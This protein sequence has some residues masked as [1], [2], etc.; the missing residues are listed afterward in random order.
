MSTVAVDW[1]NTCVKDF[2]PGEGEWLEG[3]Q[4]ALREFAKF[5]T[6]LIDSCRANF[7]EGAALIRRVLDKAGL[8]HIKIHQYPGKPFADEYVGDNYNRYTRWSETSL[9]VLRRLHAHNARAAEKKAAVSEIRASL[10]PS[11]YVQPEQPNRPK[12][13]QA[14]FGASVSARPS[15]FKTL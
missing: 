9:E 3:A 14:G 13:S 6:V 2:F 1:D 11:R 5:S 8:E 4:D 12:T 10:Y 15:V 7:P